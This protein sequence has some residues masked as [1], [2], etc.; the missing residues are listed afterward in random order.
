MNGRLHQLL[1]YPRY[2]LEFGSPCNL[3]GS[4]P[5]SQNKEL[6]KKVGKRTH[7]QWRTLHCQAAKRFFENT[8]TRL[9]MNLAIDKGFIPK[10]KQIVQLRKTMNV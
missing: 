2:I 3:N 1:H 5:E 4:I 6:A 7:Q 9:S 8:I 10:K